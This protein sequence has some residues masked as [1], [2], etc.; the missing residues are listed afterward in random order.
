MQKLCYFISNFLL[1]LLRDFLHHS[2]F[3]FLFPSPIHTIILPSPF[4]HSLVSST[5]K[6]MLFYS[7]LHLTL[8]LLSTPSLLLPSLPLP[9]TPP[10]S[11]TP[12]LNS[13][14]SSFPTHSLLVSPT[15]RLEHRPGSRTGGGTVCSLSVRHHSDTLHHRLLLQLCCVRCSLILRVVAVTHAE[16]IESPL[17][18]GAL[19]LSSE[20]QVTD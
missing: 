17:L 2:S 19:T 8:P 13:L 10:I 11:S 16:A 15:H 12:S 5:K 20:E 7:P 6:L 9:P 1:S 4:I 14:R 18:P 3:S